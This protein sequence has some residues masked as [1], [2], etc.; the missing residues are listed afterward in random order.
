MA[1]TKVMIYFWEGAG[2][3]RP[4]TCQFR[5]EYVVANHVTVHVGTPSTLRKRLKF[6][7]SWWGVELPKVF[8]KAIVGDEEGGDIYKWS[9]K[10]V[11]KNASR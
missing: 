11:R 8:W 3:C 5:L 6:I 7:K 2:E 9:G 10:K 4:E 1:L